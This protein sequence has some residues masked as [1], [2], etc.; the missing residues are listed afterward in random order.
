MHEQ[1]TKCCKRDE[2]ETDVVRVPL[3]RKGYS[4]FRAQWCLTA[5]AKAAKGPSLGTQ[6]GNKHQDPSSS[7]EYTTLPISHQQLVE[8]GVQE[9]LVRPHGSLKGNITLFDCSWWRLAR[10]WCWSIIQ[11]QNPRT[12]AHGCSLHGGCSPGCRG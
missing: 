1:S 11:E 5:G 7:C 3:H 4:S 10:D 9:S 12:S 8:N 6:Q 2:E